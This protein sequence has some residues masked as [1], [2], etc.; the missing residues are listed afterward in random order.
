MR[1]Q[2][3]NGVI[4]RILQASLAICVLFPL[5]GCNERTGDQLTGRNP[6]KPPAA[7]FVREIE[8]AGKGTWVKADTHIH[9]NFSDGSHTPNEVVAKA[10]AYGCQVIAITDHSDDNLRAGSPE[11]AKEIVAAR[12]AYPKMVILAG[13]E[14][15]IPPWDG[16]KH[17][18]VLVPSGPNEWKIL[19]E[20]KSRF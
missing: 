10:T 13:L 7:R 14:W 11:Y 20:F 1:R 15:N 17:A 5:V 19:A 4:G 9:T 3:P 6:A 18:A 8:W 2:A 12:A 16:E